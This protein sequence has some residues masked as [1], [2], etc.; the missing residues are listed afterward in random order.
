MRSP[1]LLGWHLR[2]LDSPQ[3]LWF[4]DMNGGSF[5][6]Y[7]VIHCDVLENVLSIRQALRIVGYP[8]IS[9]T[10]DSM[11]SA[12]FCYLRYQALDIKISLPIASVVLYAIA[13]M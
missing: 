11:I 12:Q 2:H 7:L 6:G 4:N 1:Q 5:Y 8:Q 10:L 13:P 9:M 3:E